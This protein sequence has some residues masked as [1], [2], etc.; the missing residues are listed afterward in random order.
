MLIIPKDP[1]IHW[2]QFYHSRSILVD[3]LCM[4]GISIRRGL[5]RMTS[6]SIPAFA[7]LL[8]A[9]EAC[10]GLTH[11]W[12]L[13]ETE[14]ID[15]TPATGILESVSGSTSATLFGTTTGV[16][17][18]PGVFPADFSYQFNGSGNGVSTTLTNVL[19]STA[20][21]SVFVTA[22]FAMNHQS[23]ARM[24]FSNNNGQ[25]GRID[26]GIN[27]TAGTP[28]QLFFFLGDPSANLSLSFTDSTVD[29]ILFDGGWH[30]VG[31]SRSGNTF[32]LYVDGVA[33]GSSGNSPI[34]ISTGTNYL[35]GRRT[36]FTGF[37]SDRISEVQ[38]FN[39]ALSQ[40]LPVL[41]AS[42]LP[43]LVLP[44]SPPGEFVPLR[45]P[46]GWIPG[47]PI[48]NSSD[49]G[50]LYLGTPSIIR[51]PDGALL[52]SHDHFGPASSGH[53][54]HIL[55]SEDGGHS[56]TRIATLDAKW[57][58]FFLH[59]DALYFMGP[60]I[61]TD[62]VLIR[63]SDDGGFTWTQPTGPTT[64]IL[65]EGS[66]H[67]SA[68]PVIEHNGRLWRTMEDQYGPSSAWGRAYRAFMMSAPV[69]ANL[70]HAAS[71][72][73]SNPLS[74][75]TNWLE[76]RM[77]AWLEG[78]AVPAPDG[79]MK[80][81]LRVHT[82]PLS[83][84]TAAVIHVSADGTTASFNPNGR[85]DLN[86]ADSSG[87]ITLPGA[88]KK[89]LI[90]RDPLDGSYWSLTSH[91]LPQDLG[92]NP[93]RTRNTLALIRSENLY[94]WD[95][96][97]ILLHHPQVDKYGFHYVDWRFD[98]EDDLIVAS[99]AAWNASSQHDS[100]LILFHHFE[101]F[102]ALDMDSSFPMGESGWEYP[103]LVIEGVG[104]RPALLANGERA[105]SNRSY[106]WQNVPGSLAGKLIARSNGNQ[107]REIN[108]TAR[109]DTT[110]VVLT[111]SSTGPP[112]FTQLG[113]LCG[114]NAGANTPMYGFSRAMSAGERIAIPQLGFSGTL[115]VIDV[116]QRP[117]AVWRVA[118]N[119]LPAVADSENAFHIDTINSL[120][121]LAAQG[122]NGTGLSFAAA[123]AP[124][125]S[126]NQLG[127][128]GMDFTLCAW[129]RTATGDPRHNQQIVGKGA[130]ERSWLLDINAGQVRFSAGSPFV[131]LRSTTAV[132]DGRWHHI[133]VVFRR[134]GQMTLH[135]NGGP[136]EDSA[137]APAIPA[138]TGPLFLGGAGAQSSFRGALDEL[139]LYPRALEVPEIRSLVLDPPLDQPV[140]GRGLPL[141]MESADPQSLALRWTAVP[142]WSYEIHR[143]ES[144]A[145]GSWQRITTI[146]AA[147]DQVGWPIA[148]DAPR[149]FFQVSPAP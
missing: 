88:T 114:Y 24:L 149:A 37:W 19:P 86:P 29:P 54:C 126:V 135:I 112:G 77:F 137:T 67:S 145:P 68:M 83:D 140:S 6:L 10:A 33:V 125:A 63:R 136:A 143:S 50:S 14:L 30:E 134:G 69:G 48:A 80:N 123:T 70:L 124:V 72:T 133:A 28:N 129:V 110:L 128:V 111:A 100:N 42:P 122:A 62:R 20:D 127:L 82:S 64:G 41:V 146:E 26:F 3:C 87:F 79:S 90:R 94:Q 56:W 132:N 130:A 2:K 49:H 115:P 13:N 108:V 66:Y 59:Q 89:F 12:A 91:I 107:T 51:L 31:I 61:A 4:V 131:T 93:E 57:S 121:P 104:F 101:N 21:F 18:N 147:S 84:D 8:V 81:V 40:G 92:G 45:D 23:G 27:G 106:V 109:R 22:R 96:R 58:S 74:S 55:R 47:N 36:A 139:R 11:R 52:A 38:V 76:G 44:P 99:R 5:K 71:W 116:G 105:F 141:A 120:G 118:P 117:L 7:T 53:P 9:T 98:G 119:A 73:S 15:S 60:N 144:L 148:I 16:V 34:A 142:G 103:D 39:E 43:T 85:P 97:S 32:Q 102:R 1:S 75:S 25:N 65:L 78:N 17:G 46:Y 113:V 35:I 95:I 138:N